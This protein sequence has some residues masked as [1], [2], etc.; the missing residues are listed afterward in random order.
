[1]LDSGLGVEGEF[2][3][4]LFSGKYTEDRRKAFFDS[5]FRCH[6]NYFDAVPFQ[7]HRMESG[8]LGL[9]YF[10]EATWFYGGMLCSNSIFSMSVEEYQNKK[11]F[12]I[13]EINRDTKYRRRC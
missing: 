9:D 13:Q 6:Q 2:A 12:G 11:L 1:M 7:C 3:T 4:D 5:I 10:R 8:K